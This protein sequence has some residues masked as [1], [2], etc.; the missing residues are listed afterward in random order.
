MLTV[1]LFMQV[2]PFSS[3]DDVALAELDDAETSLLK[4]L[5]GGSPLSEA[6][7]T[8][9]RNF[10]RRYNKALLEKLT[11]EREKARLAAENADIKG[12]L[13]QVCSALLLNPLRVSV[14]SGCPY[15][16]I[17]VFVHLFEY[18]FVSATRLSELRF[19]WDAPALC[20]RQFT[21]TGTLPLLCRPSPFLFPLRHCLSTLSHCRCSARIC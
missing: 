18:L 8:A 2:F 11:L 10:H 16:M 7:A 20:E 14:S 21:T 3:P 5:A 19:P 6:E 1:F 17:R 9:L 13:Q 12:L 4:E 15:R